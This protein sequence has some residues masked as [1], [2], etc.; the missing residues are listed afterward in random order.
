MQISFYLGYFLVGF[1]KFAFENRNVRESFWLARAGQNGLWALG[2]GFRARPEVTSKKERKREK[3]LGR[4]TAG[5]GNGRLRVGRPIA[6][7]A[8][9]SKE[10]T[11]V[12]DFVCAQN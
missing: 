12:H 5:W 2:F 4:A 11:R 3:R 1:F 7:A 8:E 6:V 9:S 10:S